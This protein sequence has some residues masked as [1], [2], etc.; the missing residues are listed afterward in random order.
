ME[1]KNYETSS[2]QVTF[3]SLQKFLEKQAAKAQR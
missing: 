3:C 2:Q 1:S